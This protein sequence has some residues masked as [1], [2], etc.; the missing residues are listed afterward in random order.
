MK[1]NLLIIITIVILTGAYSINELLT[2]DS[3]T[4][5]IREI[6]VINSSNGNKTI[7]YT[8]NLYS[9]SQI[10]EFVAEPNI[11]GGNDDSVLNLKFDSHTRR[12]TVV[13]YYVVPKARAEEDIEIKFCLNDK[14]CQANS[15]LNP[16]VF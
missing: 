16:A 8:I 4:I 10:N 13:Y 3:P 7:C 12:A 15:K 2:F 9:P 14:L 1:A 6:N 11:A 5:K